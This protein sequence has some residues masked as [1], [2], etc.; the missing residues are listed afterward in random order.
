MLYSTKPASVQD[1]DLCA[2]A[3]GFRRG[4]LRPREVICYAVNLLVA[5]SVDQD[6]ILLASG[7]DL[8]NQELSAHLAAAAGETCDES[9][10][11]DQLRLLLLRRLQ[12]A[13]LSPTDT[14]DKLQVLYADFGYPEDMRVCSIYSVEGGCPLVAMDRVITALAHRLTPT[15]LRYAT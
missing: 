12:Q 7:E 14:T 9:A 15:A 5:G 6:V 2:V 4:W 8:D 3:Q 1:L 13:N 10:A 11:F